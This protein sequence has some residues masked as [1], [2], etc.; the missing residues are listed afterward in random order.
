M[1]AI[2]T[3]A[4]GAYVCVK[5]ITE[6]ISCSFVASSIFSKAFQW[7]DPETAHK[8]TIRILSKGISP[9]STAHS[10]DERLKVCLWNRKFRNPIG[11]AAGYK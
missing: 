3:I 10:V 6:D 1:V 5:S 8:W 11:M 9:S 4:S 2:S 7:I